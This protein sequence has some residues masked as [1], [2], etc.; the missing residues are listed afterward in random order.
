MIP[1]I[2]G[3]YGMRSILIFSLFLSAGLLGAEENHE[4]AESAKP[5]LTSFTG[6]LT[7]NKVRMRV[8]PTLDA[9]V[10]RE[11]AQG[12]LMI[13]TGEID[14][15]YS[16]MPP[17][18][19]KAYIFRTY[20]L[21]NT[22]EGNRVNVRIEPT[23]DAPIIAQL[24]TGDKVSG[25]I[26]P[27]NNKWLEIPMPATARFYVAKEYIEKIGDVH[28]MAQISR[29]RDEVNQLLSNTQLISAS[30]LQKPYPEIKLDPL[31]KNYHKIIDQAKDFP[32]QAAKAKELLQKLQDT[33]LQKKIAYLESRADS[34][35]QAISNAPQPD[36]IK[37]PVTR[38]AV[39]D[40]MAAWNDLEESAYREWQEHHPGQS[41]DEFIQDQLATS[42][43]LKGLLEPYTK[44]IKNKPGD[45][46]LVNPSTHCI[47]AYLYS[48]RVNL[49]DY[50]GQ[51]IAVK[52]APRPNNNFAFPAY[53]VIEL[54]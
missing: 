2:V 37:I 23:V 53:F 11:L 45:Y 13:I 54:E 3:G 5:S 18:G 42:K 52:A 14:D 44:S 29:K 4:S 36:V 41:T 10:I 20:V 16:V 7:K 40:K 50:V 19:A 22:V 43:H 12:D 33:Y 31:V 6:R 46:V 17:Q 15:F 21:D 39:T 38:P 35:L 25:S 48:N 8:Q 51:E 30:E 34:H 9:A 47:I 49:A 1:S 26:S 32:D 28:L 27:L 24:N